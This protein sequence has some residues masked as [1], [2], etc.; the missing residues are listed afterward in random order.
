MPKNDVVTLKLLRNDLGQI[1]DGLCVRQDSWR[2]TQQYL[3]TG[4]VDVEQ[5]IEEC[6]KPE[7]A[8][9]IADYYDKIIEKIQQQLQ[10]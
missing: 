7:E 6:S 10:N 8:Q 5:G 2:Y 3:E 9:N 1:I 4:Y